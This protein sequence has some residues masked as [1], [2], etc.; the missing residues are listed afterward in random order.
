MRLK[1][2][3]NGHVSICS[4]G[5]SRW[6]VRIILIGKGL[7]CGLSH[8]LLRLL[9]GGHVDGDLRGGERGRSNKLQSLVAD[10]LSGEPEEGLLEVVVGLGGDI[11][12]LEV[13]LAMEG[14]G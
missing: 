8:L 2:A 11:V 12:V 5:G 3:A 9:H 14:N 7:L 13:L 4:P 10:E 1:V 6:D